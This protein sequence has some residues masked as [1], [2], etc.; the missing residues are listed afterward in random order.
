MKIGMNILFYI[1]PMLEMGRPYWKEAWWHLSY[2]LI[3]TLEKDPFHLY[4]F[5]V[6][7]NDGIK[8]RIKQ[9]HLHQ[10]NIIAIPQDKLL[11]KFNLDYW[12]ASIAWYTGDFTQDQLRYSTDLIRETLGTFIPDI[13]ITY[14]PVPFVREA[15]PNAVI[16]HAESG[17]ITRPPFPVTYQLDPAGMQK[18]SGLIKY[19]TTIRDF[20]ISTT[21]KALVESFRSYFCELIKAK[22]PFKDFI[23]QNKDRFDYLVITPLQFSGNFVFDGNCNFSSQFHFAQYV[24]SQIPKNVGVIFTTHPEY[25]VFSDDVVSYLSS[26][27]ENF[28][29][30]P[31]FEDIYAPTQ[32]L[33]YGI[34][35]V[36]SVSSSVGLQSL[37]WQKKLIALGNSQLRLAADATDLTAIEE[38]LA[39]PPIDRDNV[40]F[41]LL[42][43]YYIPIKYLYN[44]EWLSKHL[45]SVLSLH[46]S[47]EDHYS[48]FTP[49]DNPAQ[50]INGLIEDAINGIPIRLGKN[51]NNE[52]KI[53][54]EQ[55]ETHIRQQEATIKQQETRIHQQEATIQQLQTNLNDIYNTRVW[56]L[57]QRWWAFKEKILGPANFHHQES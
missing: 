41:W 44:P 55:Y 4:N 9:E 8:S 38:V 45:S 46:R 35:G 47:G 51:L 13:V 30:L 29:Y 10:Y 22:S 14:T 52:L 6:I 53:K 32:Y 25:P 26:V 33:M 17:I 34:D 23:G 1:E 11:A 2:L 50:V 24:L 15:F 40:L 19:Q 36:V 57:A 49:I 39:A 43:Q 7:T 18:D 5:R 28:L 48:F 31:E 3:E 37:I 42:T 27:Y 54:L 20:Q 21:E 56:R 12:R 16:L